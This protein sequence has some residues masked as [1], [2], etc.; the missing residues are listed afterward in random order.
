MRVVRLELTFGVA[1]NELV[2][3]VVII[4]D[5]QFP[6]K[7]KPKIFEMEAGSCG[8]GGG[9]PLYVCLVQYGMNDAIISEAI[10]R[11]ARLKEMLRH[12]K[13]YVEQERRALKEALS[14]PSSSQQG[15]GAA[16][17]QQSPA[18]KSASASA[19]ASQQQSPLTTRKAP[20]LSHFTLGTATEAAAFA[21]RAGPLEVEEDEDE[22][23]EGDEYD[24]AADA[25][26][27][28]SAHNLR[29][30]LQDLSRHLAQSQDG[31]I[32]QTVA[33]MG[34]IS[35]RIVQRNIPL[36]LLKTPGGC[37]MT[38]A[39]NDVGKMHQVLKQYMRTSDYKYGPALTEPTAIAWVD[40]RT[41]LAT[42]LES[43]SF[44]VFWKF[45]LHVTD[46]LQKACAPATVRSAFEKAGTGESNR[47]TMQ[48]CVY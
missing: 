17:S 20:P 12:H 46:L 39:V 35:A 15:Q 45:L 7:D 40:L 28:M 32:G 47:P 41:L 16:S 31:A 29:A 38:C 23:D 27:A 10:F 14:S 22:E 44:Q 18:W 33:C 43:T 19:S 21:R 25:A 1:G 13:A 34:P 5:R 9:S 8:L 6:W 3:R 48:L 24:D 2:C 26:P 36:L 11:K 37:S 42:H 30:P 4:A